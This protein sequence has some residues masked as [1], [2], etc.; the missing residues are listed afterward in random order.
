MKRELVLAP[1][2]VCQVDLGNIFNAL[3]VKALS[4]GGKRRFV[5]IETGLEAY[6]KGRYILFAFKEGCRW[7]NITDDWNAQIVS[8]A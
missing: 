4:A 6:M 3:L 1:L 7:F 5:E 8:N 2:G